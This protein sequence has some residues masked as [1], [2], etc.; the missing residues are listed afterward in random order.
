MW[1]DHPFNQ[2]NKT[3]KIAVEVKVGGNGK[4]GLDKILKK[5]GRQCRGV[6]IYRRV[7]GTLC[8]L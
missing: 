8:Q 4:E 6:F 5:W 7:L 3:S 2:R 1:Y